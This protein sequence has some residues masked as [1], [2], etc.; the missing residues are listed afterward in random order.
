MQVVSVEIAAALARATLV[1]LEHPCGLEK[2]HLS[3]GGNSV[4]GILTR[5]PQ[6]QVLGKRMWRKRRGLGTRGQRGHAHG[7]CKTELQEVAGV[8]YIFPPSPRKGIPSPEPKSTPP[9]PQPPPKH[10]GHQCRKVT[11]ESPPRQTPL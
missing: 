8:P 10:E 1:P 3:F 4:T 11:P 5:K 2:F 7:N 6:P 9:P